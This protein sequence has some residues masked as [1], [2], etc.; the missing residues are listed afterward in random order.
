MSAVSTTW[1]E[2]EASGARNA[3]RQGSDDFLNIILRRYRLVLI[4]LAI[5]MTAAVTAV[6]LLPPRYSARAVMRV[7]TDDIDTSSLESALSSTRELELRRDHQIETQLQLLSSRPL[8]RNVV[9]TLALYDDQEFNPGGDVRGKAKPKDVRARVRGSVSPLVIEAVTD[10]LIGAVKVA[11]DGQTSFLN[12]DVTSASAAKAARIANKIASTYVETQVA[13]KKASNLRAIQALQRQVADLHEQLLSGERGAASY[14]R[15]HRLDGTPS[16]DNA[17]LQVG[18]L[19]GDLAA[20]RAARAAADA[21]ARFGSSGAD[22]MSSTLLTNLREQETDARRRLADLATSFGSGHPDVQKS[23]AQLTEIQHAIAAESVRVR[24]DMGRETAAQQA[25]EAQLS[26]ELR[27]VQARSLDDLITAVPLGDMQRTSDAT[28]AIYIGLLG[29]LDGLLRENELVRPDATIAFAALP[30]TNPSSRTG[31]RILVIAFAGSVL[32]SLLLVLIVEQLDTKIRTAAQVRRNTGLPT[33]GML[34]ELRRW[35]REQLARPDLIDQPYSTFTEEVRSIFARLGRL[36]PQGVGGVV[37]LTSPEPGDGKTTLAL[38]LS[39]AAVATERSVILVDL[40]LRRPA[41]CDRFG[42]SPDEPDLLSYLRGEAPLERVIRSCPT[43]PALKSIGALAAAD[44]PG[45][46]IANRRLETLLHQLRARFDLIII[47]TPPV[48]AASDAVTLAGTADVTL[49]VV[50]WGHTSEATLR[51][52][53]AEMDELPA[54]V[55]LN[56]VSPAVH[57]RGSYANYSSQYDQRPG[58]RLGR[59]RNPSREMLAKSRE[60]GSGHADVASG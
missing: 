18:Q 3:D 37:L 22:G 6:M 60:L 57:P 24:Q 58:R 16:G 46:M 14:K 9:Q 43:V 30:P 54:G 2:R 32:L 26:R 38:A 36:L 15:Q 39:A 34:P 35:R 13:E 49:L 7:N 27:G 29:R 44:D 19:A 42:M 51:E 50:N 53:L 12:V 28:R 52:A 25:R 47:N 21:K 41:L 20:A 8:M 10:R 11:Q 48:L 40:D 56:R 23:E 33:L 31:A 4:C 45:A 1:Q 59:A 55:V 5:G 17:A